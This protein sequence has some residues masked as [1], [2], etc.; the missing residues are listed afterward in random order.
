M[1][2]SISWRSYKLNRYILKNIIFTSLFIS[3]FSFS[4]NAQ[5]ISF[6]ASEGY[7]LGNINGQ[8]HWETTAD[9][10]GGNVANQTITNEAAS[11]GENSLKIVKET[12]FP[13]QPQPMVGGFYN[14]PESISNASATFSADI[15]INSLQDSQALTFLVGL[16]YFDSGEGRYRTYLNFHHQGYVE[17]F[18]TGGLTGIMV[19]YTGKTWAPNTWYNIKIETVGETVKFFIDNEEI[20][21]GILVSDGPVDQIRFVHDN[22]DGIVYIDNVSTIDNALSVGTTETSE[23]THFYDKNNKTLSVNSANS[24]ILRIS[25]F[26]VLGQLMLD[27][28][29]AANSETIE[30]SNFMDGI[31]FV[32]MNIGNGIKTIKVLKN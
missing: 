17:V 18:V 11:E 15:Y 25:V 30:M 29:S 5:H 19:D 2:A 31:Y 10:Q 24:P 13:G 32:K 3:F 27:E 28:N 23:I 7:I 22:Y 6:E 12:D 8:S 1:T 16:V 9:D 26:N 4:A 20:Y 21:Q 14:Y